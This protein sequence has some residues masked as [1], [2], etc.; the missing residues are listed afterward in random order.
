MSGFFPS[1]KG[2][3]P[4]QV[5]QFNKDGFLVIE[6][7]LS[8]ETV[9]SLMVETHSLLDNFSLEDHPLTKFATGGEDGKDH[10]GDDYFLSSGDKVRFF[11]E[12]GMYFPTNNP[13]P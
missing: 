7:A 9:E 11:F 12:E 3:S 4:D 5:E 1:L 8:P 13:A 6:G 10:V 2:L